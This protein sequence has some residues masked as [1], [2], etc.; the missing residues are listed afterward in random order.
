MKKLRLHILCSLAAVLMILL[1]CFGLSNFARKNVDELSGRLDALPQVCELQEIFGDPAS[2]KALLA[3]V[4]SLCAQTKKA[5]DRLA[6]F[7]HYSYIS[8]ACAASEELYNAVLARSPAHF[9]S[10]ESA[11][12]EALGSMR[13]LESPSLELF[14]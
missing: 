14:L 8:R 13:R 6:F 1:F 5:G 2:H 4:S 10:A 7:I 11:L 3:D 12:R 9:G